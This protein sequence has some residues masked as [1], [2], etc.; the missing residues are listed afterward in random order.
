MDKSLTDCMNEGLHIRLT[1]RGTCSISTVSKV[2][3]NEESRGQS[4]KSPSIWSIQ[5]FA[6]LFSVVD[7]Y[8]FLDYLRIKILGFLISD[9]KTFRSDGLK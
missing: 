8:S 5:I 2:P 3:P 7:R 9:L 1:A 6:W 4:F